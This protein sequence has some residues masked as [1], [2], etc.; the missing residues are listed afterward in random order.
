MWEAVRPDCAAMSRKM[1]TGAVGLLAGDFFSVRAGGILATG[2]V[3][4]WGA[5]WAD[6]RPVKA[7]HKI[8]ICPARMHSDCSAMGSSAAVSAAVLRGPSPPLRG[9]DALGTAGRMP[10]LLV[11]VLERI[12]ARLVPRHESGVVFEQVVKI[13]GIGGKRL[14]RI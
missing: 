9:R 11:G 8:I 2:S 14:A 12:P 13:L 4:P 10:A 5:L 6:S 7:I 3:R 1:G